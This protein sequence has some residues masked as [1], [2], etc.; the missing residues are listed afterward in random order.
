M[1][2]YPL[3]RHRVGILT[4]FAASLAVICI[5]LLTGNSGARAEELPANT[6]SDQKVLASAL[7][8]LQQNPDTV[9]W[10]KIGSIID[11]PVVQGEGEFYLHHNFYGQ[12]SSAGTVFLDEEC[13]ISPK[14]EHMVLYGHNMKNGTM[15]GELDRY[16]DL[17]YLKAN[18]VI[19]FDTLYEEGKYVVVAV[20]DISGETEDPHFMQMLRFDFVDN[21]DFMTFYFDARWKSYFKVP[22]DV[23]YGDKLLSLIT[24]SYSLYDGRLIVMLRELR[25]D[26]DPQQVAALMQSAVTK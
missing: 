6:P 1:K 7:P 3:I 13:S 11:T 25:P 12:E 5:F 4:V 20:Y 22:V 8:Y 26:E 24:C 2:R 21:E 17:S 14:S 15:F 19:T 9:G 18:P 16:R 23:Q 10:L